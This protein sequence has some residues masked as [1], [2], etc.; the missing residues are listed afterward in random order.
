MVRHA[1]RCDWKVGSPWRLIFRDGRVADAGEIA[2]IDPPKR[3]V[4]K[5]R[6]EWQPDFKAEG[7]SRCT[8]EL[9]PVDKAVKLTIT[10]VMDRADSKLIQAVSGGWPI[11]L[12]NLKS[13]IETGEIVLNTAK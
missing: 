1:L 2:E 7:Y 3:I 12:S 10:H 8:F 5:W 4:V 11:I 13:L 9:E 6:N